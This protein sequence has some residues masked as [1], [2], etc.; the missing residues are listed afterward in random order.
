MAR[1]IDKNRCVGCGACE[2]SCIV[3][4]ISEKENRKREINETACVDCGAC[5]MI[6]PVKCISEI[7]AN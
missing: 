7:G 5:E 6:C 1:I 2:R 3:G 4:C